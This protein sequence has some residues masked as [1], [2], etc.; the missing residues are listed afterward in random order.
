MLDE[1]HE[2]TDT[3]LTSK[4][5]HNHVKLQTGRQYFHEL[6]AASKR[7]TRMLEVFHRFRDGALHIAA[8]DYPVQGITLAN[9]SPTEFTAR[10]LSKTVRFSFTYDHAA[11]RGVVAMTTVSPE[12]ESTGPNWSFHFNGEGEV[13]DIEPRPNE[14]IYNVGIDADAAEIVLAALHIALV[15]KMEAV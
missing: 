12:G 7:Y 10:F 13:G 11:L 4:T 1:A 5:F 3:R 6:D 9:V 2:A 8:A 15:G 14:G